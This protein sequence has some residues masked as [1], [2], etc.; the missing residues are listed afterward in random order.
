[1]DSSIR[2]FQNH[3]TGFLFLILAIFAFVG[4]ACYTLAKTTGGAHMQFSEQLFLGVVACAG[5]Y[6]VKKARQLRDL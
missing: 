1:M 4:A 6:F 5:F 2:N 3:N